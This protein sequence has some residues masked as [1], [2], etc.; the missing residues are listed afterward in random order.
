MNIS[1]SASG[2]AAALRSLE[3]VT[4][5]KAVLP[6]LSHVLIDGSDGQATLSCTDTELSLTRTLNA[7]IE[8]VGRVALPAKP[9]LDIVSQITEPDVHII[10]EKNAARIAA[11]Q[12]KLRMQAMSADEFPNIVTHADKGVL[13]NGATFRSLIRRVRPCISAT[14]KRYNIA[15]AL[16]VMSDKVTAV[17]T[18]D[19]KRLAISTQPAVGA[20]EQSII[21][22]TR[23]ID[24]LI[25][26]DAEDYSFSVSDN[27]IFFAS[28]QA[29]LSSRMLSED[30][31]PNYQRIIPQDNKNIVTIQRDLFLAALKRVSLVANEGRGITYNVAGTVMT[32]QARSVEL[33]EATEN[34]A[35]T[36]TGE[37][38]QVTLHATAVTDFLEA[39][40]NPSITIAIGGP[41][42]AVLFNDGADFLTVAMSMR[43]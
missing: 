27:H 35:V 3:K 26:D 10:V 32:M 14:E 6:I 16:L 20:V 39:A 40:R 19:G 25:Q 8:K 21:L 29:I 18:T 12:F 2:L 36:Y 22:P 17:V 31:F 34:L 7:Q 15:G 41:N 28:E 4:P 13:L 24:T 43:A 11:G 5:A 9:L 38:T 33:G 1:I 30:K 37:P 23:L 42:A